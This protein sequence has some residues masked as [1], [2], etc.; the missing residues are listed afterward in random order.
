M[1]ISMCTSTKSFISLLARY[2]GIDFYHRTVILDCRARAAHR[3][4]CNTKI[5]YELNVFKRKDKIAF[6]E[7]KHGYDFAITELENSHYEVLIFV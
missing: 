7:L 6:K 3:V 5:R 4:G 1:F 2:V